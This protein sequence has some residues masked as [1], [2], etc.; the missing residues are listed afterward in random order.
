VIVVG[1]V[2]YTKRVPKS[3]KQS[4][5]RQ[6]ADCALNDRS[7]L[8]AAGSTSN[9]TV[10]TSCY[11]RPRVY[12]YR[13]TGMWVVCGADDGGNDVYKTVRARV[14]GRERENEL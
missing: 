6:R 12:V 3:T 8:S 4:A 13:C 2:T 1:V 9:Q 11:D 7:A 14:N 10:E 5:S